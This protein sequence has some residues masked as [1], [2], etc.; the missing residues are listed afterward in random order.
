V[1]ITRFLV[2]GHLVPVTLTALYLAPALL[3]LYAFRDVQAR[4]VTAALIVS[5]VCYYGG[6]YGAARVRRTWKARRAAATR[7]LRLSPVALQ[8][9]ALVTLGIYG[10]LVLYLA[11]TSTDI[12][13]LAAL[14]SANVN[15]ITAARE[16]FVQTRT[17][18][19]SIVRYLNAMFLRVLVPVAVVILYA[20]RHRWRHVALAAMLLCALLSLEKTLTAFIL[21]PLGV[22]L[23]LVGRTRA[24]A[25]FV[26]A[27][28]LVLAATILGTG[29]LFELRGHVATA[30]TKLLT[31]SWGERKNMFW[32]LEW[33]M[34]G[35]PGKPLHDVVQQ[36]APEFDV[37]EDG[38]IMPKADAAAGDRDESPDAAAAARS[39]TPASHESSLTGGDRAAAAPGSSVAGAD[40][41][42][43]APDHGSPRPD[44]SASAPVSP[45]SSDAP[46]TPAS[47]TPSI[48]PT[49]AASPGPVRDAEAW[50]ALHYRNM[51]TNGDM[52]IT[53]HPGRVFTPPSSDYVAGRWLAVLTVGKLLT[54]QQSNDAP[55]GFTQSLALTVARAYEPQRGDAFEVLQHIEGFKL[56]DLALGSSEAGTMA[57]S[58]W[59]K[60]SVPG[61][62][63]VTVS[64]GRGTRSRLVRYTVLK[65]HEWERKALV[66]PGDSTGGEREW[67]P[68]A[69]EALRINFNFGAG[70]AYHTDRVEA[71]QDGFFRQSRSDAV[72]FIAQPGA[73]FHLTGVQLEEG[74]TPT[75]FEHRPLEAERALL[76]K[77]P[78]MIGGTLLETAPPAIQR[79]VAP[80][81]QD[82]RAQALLRRTQFILNRIVW[83]PYITAYDWFGFYREVLRERRLAGKTIGIVA[84]AQGAERYPIEQEV[85]KYQHGVYALATATANAVYFADAYVNFG[86][87]GVVL[88]SLLIGVIFYVICASRNLAVK[89]VSVMSVFSLM[90]ASFPANM[91]SG[92]LALLLLLAWLLREPPAPE[93]PA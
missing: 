92:G 70:Q 8:R 28:F 40:R 60:A 33:L 81:L 54:F 1:R 29:G 72:T 69:L 62:Y 24:V 48:E 46:Q 25:A 45:A 74:A 39:D 35:Q 7:S 55:P 19:E 38:R 31:D 32:I 12:A 88:Y 68:Q 47:A 85:F 30:P 86:W 50:R 80:V 57:L 89:A 26:L 75:P 9:A 36:N 82:Y 51:I 63:N 83:V 5:I 13:L 71:W 73:T 15:E 37:S 20:C 22:Y 53:E 27:G 44:G 56:R 65:P 76:Y 10:L 18:S 52:R 77:P 42:A 64:N 61:I 84:R 3:G 6:F 2:A 4:L 14:R 21:V 66:V 91:L 16:A 43:A 67:P 87:A 59:V 90:V 23:L 79:Y 93:S 41:A 78:R 11:I 58:F 34:A 17:G 49:S